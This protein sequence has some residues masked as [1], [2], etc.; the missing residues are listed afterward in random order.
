MKKNDINE[1]FGCGCHDL[2][3]VVHLSYFPP[4]SKEIGDN[5]IYVH[6]FLNEWRGCLFPHWSEFITLDKCCSIYTKK[7]L[8]DFYNNSIYKRF[9]IAAK[10]LFNKL[11]EAKTTLLDTTLFNA[12]DLNRLN[13]ML[14]NLKSEEI[15]IQEIPKVYELERPSSTYRLQFVIED[16]ERYADFDPMLPPPELSTNILF[17]KRNFIKRFWIALKYSFGHVTSNYGNI[18]EFEITPKDAWVIRKMIEKLQNE[19]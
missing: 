6:L 1:Y 8:L 19:K 13:D 4:S 2:N 7:N 15:E 16:W 14:S 12:Q 11:N 18:D 9:A 3:H 17:K 5:V 10:Y